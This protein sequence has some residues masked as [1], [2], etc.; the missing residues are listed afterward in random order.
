MAEDDQTIIRGTMY[1]E[2]L[3]PYYKLYV[4]RLEANTNRSKLEVDV[5]VRVALKFMNENGFELEGTGGGCTAWSTLINDKVYMLTSLDSSIA[6][7]PDEDC[8]FSGYDEDGCD[9]SCIQM[10]FG[11]FMEVWND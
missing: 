1:D 3:A 10:N 9:I 4:S 6:I 8:Y 5:C 11:D 7:F 2:E